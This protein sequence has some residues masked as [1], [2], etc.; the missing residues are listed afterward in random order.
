MPSGFSLYSARSAVSLRTVSTRCEEASAN[1]PFDGTVD[2]PIMGTTAITECDSLPEI[3]NFLLTDVD[4]SASILA[5]SDHDS[6]SAASASG[7][8]ALQS[9]LPDSHF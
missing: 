3:I 6:A 2:R 7:T 5:C 4:W 8:L 9:R 1:Q